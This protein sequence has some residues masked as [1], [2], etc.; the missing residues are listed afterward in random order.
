MN[1]IHFFMLLIKED[2]LDK[3]LNKIYPGIEIWFIGTR[4]LIMKY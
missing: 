2:R 3:K 4:V 1:I